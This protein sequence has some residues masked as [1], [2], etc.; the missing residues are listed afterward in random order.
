MATSGLRQVGAAGG[1]RRVLVVDDH[2]VFAQLLRRALED[3]PDL[4][5]VGIAATVRDAQEMA[6]RLRPDTVLMDVQ[7]RDGDGVAA[8]TDLVAA[9]PEI[10]V[11]VVSA[12][13][14]GT[15]LRRAAAAGAC[16]LQPKDGDLDEMLHAV[17]TAR[18]GTFAV[19]PRLL[20]EAVTSDPVDLR[21]PTLTSRESDVLQM[22]AAGLDTGVIARELGISVNT[23]RSYVKN[24]LV[25]L[26]AHSQLE[27]VVVAMRSGLIRTDEVPA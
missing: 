22:L 1:I 21:V 18:A 14:D 3:E 12:F 13:I 24:L 8:T 4:E 25:K 16:A 17:R 9:D 20:R 23:C 5:C 7:L 19:H 15:L 2:T 6:V 26:G 27:A 11:V 10:R